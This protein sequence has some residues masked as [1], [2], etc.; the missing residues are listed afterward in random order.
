MLPQTAV[1]WPSSVEIGAGFGVEQLTF[2]LNKTSGSVVEN[3]DSPSIIFIRKSIDQEKVRDFRHF[4][5]HK[6]MIILY[7]S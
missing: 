3:S 7:F 5:C 4:K 6:R 1:H 2:P